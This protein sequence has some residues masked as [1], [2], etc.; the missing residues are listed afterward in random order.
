MRDGAGKA[1]NKV[2]FVEIGY[3]RRNSFVNTAWSH[4]Q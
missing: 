4:Q 3:R 2:C 1:E